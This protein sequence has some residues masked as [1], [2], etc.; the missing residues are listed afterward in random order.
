[1][2]FDKERIERLRA[3]LKEIA[4]TDYPFECAM[5]LAA[6]DADDA[7]VEAHTAKWRDNHV[8]FTATSLVHSGKDGPHLGPRET[9]TIC[10]MWDQIEKNAI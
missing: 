5:A 6:L 9:C 2:S 10:D 4:D 8:S 1:M 7:A 3:A